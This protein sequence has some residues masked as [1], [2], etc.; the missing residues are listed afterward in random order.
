[1]FDNYR[2]S[3][4]I[5]ATKMYIEAVT[6]KT[7]CHVSFL[8]QIFYCNFLNNTICIAFYFSY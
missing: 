8:K 1:M 6:I 4:C 5:D 3:G 2:G 7:V